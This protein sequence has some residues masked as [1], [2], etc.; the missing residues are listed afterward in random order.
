MVLINLASLT[1]TVVT[2]KAFSTT[3]STILLNKKM[4]WA[5]LLTIFSAK[6]I[7]VIFASI[8]LIL[9]SVDFVG[10]VQK[11]HHISLTG[12][13]CPPA[14]ALKRAPLSEFAP[15]HVAS[16]SLLAVGN[17]FIM[18]SRSMQ[19]VHNEVLTLE[20]RAAGEINC[21]SPSFFFLH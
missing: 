13:F 6:K 3:H 11:Q 12:L 15:F 14:W 5:L 20:S 17:M 7:L 9:I 21:L 2:N 8:L 10:N 18:S 16:R 1:L 19:S 4:Y